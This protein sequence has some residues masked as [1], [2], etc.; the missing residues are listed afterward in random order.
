[1]IPTQFYT[2]FVYFRDIDQLQNNATPQW[3]SGSVY[4]W[5]PCFLVLHH[6]LPQFSTAAVELYVCIHVR[7]VS[8]QQPD[9][10][11]WNWT[12][13]HPLLSYWSTLQHLLLN[14]V[15]WYVRIY[16][17]SASGQ[18]TAVSPASID[19]PLW[20]QQFP[21]QRLPALWC[22]CQRVTLNVCWS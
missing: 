11:Y 17:F 6:I 3:Q 10:L 20:L 12:C 13:R 9:P 14:V 16:L 1:M 5:S 2:S 7:K 18:T 15:V 19:A 4:E 22:S 8:A 21:S